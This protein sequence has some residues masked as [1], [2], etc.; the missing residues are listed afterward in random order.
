MHELNQRS[1]P[2]KALIKYSQ[3]GQ[4]WMKFQSEWQAPLEKADVEPPK[5]VLQ[6]IRRLK[7]RQSVARFALENLDDLPDYQKAKAFFEHLHSQTTDPTEPAIFNLQIRRHEEEG[8][9]IKSERKRLHKEL[10]LIEKQLQ[11]LE[12]G[13]D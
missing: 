13:L 9:R 3:I 4:A 10:E 11:V 12:R 5:K 2:T 6:K 8:L 1:L 7:H